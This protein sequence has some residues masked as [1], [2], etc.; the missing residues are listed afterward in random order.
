MAHLRAQPGAVGVGAAVAEELPG[1]AD[2][3]D[4]IEVEVGHHELVLVLAGAARKSAARVDEV[5]V[6]VELADVPRRLGADAVDGAD[7]VAVGDGV[8]R[9]LDLPQVLGEA[10]HG[11]RLG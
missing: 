5:R 4:Q 1:A 8:G 3:L 2:L 7:V 10:G 6:A 11:G 9:L